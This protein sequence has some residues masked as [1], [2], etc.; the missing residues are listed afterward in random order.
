[1]KQD[2]LVTTH[3]ETLL[4][5]STAVDTQRVA[6]SHLVIVRAPGLLPMLYRPSELAGEL[7]VSAAIVRDWVEKGLPH[8]RD[9]RGHVWIDGRQ[10]AEWVTVKRQRPTGSRMAE[11]QAYCFR[12]CRA[13]ELRDPVAQYHGKQALLSGVCPQCGGIINRGSRH[14]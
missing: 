9:H 13:V 14:G 3:E 12:C 11:D 1:M 7:G 6:L 10:V 4:G 8:Q 2:G 5:H